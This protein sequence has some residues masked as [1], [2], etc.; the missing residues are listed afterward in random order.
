[1]NEPNTKARKNRNIIWPSLE[2]VD[3]AKWATKQ[4]MLAAVICASLTGL[5]AILAICGVEFVRKTFQITGASLID[6][7]IFGLIAFFL[8]RQS[9]FAA[10][11][12]LIVYVIE[13]V[14]SWAASPAS[15][16]NFIMPLIFTMAFITGVRG[17][18]AYHRLR[19]TTPPESQ[20]LAA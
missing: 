14:F 15:Q 1:M 4:A 3:D 17:A 7:A 12:G 13:R 5:F 16:T 19:E 18:H 9:R 6:A 10:W 2:T 20:R 11:S 8:S